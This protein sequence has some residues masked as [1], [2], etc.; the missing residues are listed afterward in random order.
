MASGSICAG[1]NTRY[2]ARVRVR[3]DRLWTL[4]GKPTKS[5]RVALKR[6]AGAFSD[7]IYY[8]GDVLLL[9]DLFDPE[10]MCEIVER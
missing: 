2:Q 8:R 7:Q 9:A 10:Q 5:Y 6:M 3:G 4:I 1:T